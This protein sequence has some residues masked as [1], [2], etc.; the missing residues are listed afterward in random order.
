MFFR[1]ARYFFKLKGN[2]IGVLVLS[3][4]LDAL[5][6]NSLAVAPHY[7]RQ[8]IATY[9]LSQAEKLAKRSGKTSLKL[10]VLKTNTPAQRT[11]K[12]FGLTTR[13]QKKWSLILTKRL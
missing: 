10:S 3:E 12:K 7:R 8:G 5:F 6:I 2:I 9:M 13:E 4:K 1:K 11:Y